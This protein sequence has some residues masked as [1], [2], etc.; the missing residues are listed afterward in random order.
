MVR[1]DQ[2]ID[3][4]TKAQQNDE[5]CKK[6]IE[7]KGKEGP[8]GR[9]WQEDDFTFLSNGLLATHDGRVVVPETLR[10]ELLDAHQTGG[11]FG[12]D[13]SIKRRKE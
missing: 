9:K 1:N 12:E 7:V 3:D 8:Q 5:L 10:E 6:T 13:K 4:W 2:F 11:H